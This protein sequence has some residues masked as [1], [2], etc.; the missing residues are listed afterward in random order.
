M[1]ITKHH[2]PYWQA[3]S[4]PLM[5]SASPN[6]IN[7]FYIKYG[8]R[9]CNILNTSKIGSIMTMTIKVPV[10]QNVMPCSQIKICRCFR[11]SCCLHHHGTWMEAACSSENFYQPTWHTSE[12]TA[13][14]IFN[15]LQIFQTTFFLSL[16]FYKKLEKYQF[17]SDTKVWHQF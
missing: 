5:H 2:I 6:P 11:V 12:N 7:P 3:N 17:Q 14:F 9:Y 4:T 15:M 1:V 10:F 16:G 8:E 13:N